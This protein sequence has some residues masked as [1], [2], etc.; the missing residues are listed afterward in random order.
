M[1]K[2]KNKKKNKENIKP[3]KLKGG[4]EENTNKMIV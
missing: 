3:R 4:T 2:K 1:L